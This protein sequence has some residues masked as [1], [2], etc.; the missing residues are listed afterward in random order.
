MHNVSFWRG[1]L[2]AGGLMVLCGCSEAIPEAELQEQ[3][4]PIVWQKSG[5]YSHLGRPVRILARDRATL[6]QVPVTEIPVD[7][8]NEMVLIAGVG[9]TPSSEVG[10][11]IARVW[12]KGSRIRVQEIQTH[13]GPDQQR[14]LNPASPWAVAVIPRSD[15]NVEGYSVAVPRGLIAP[16]PRAG[17][18]GAASPAG[19][20]NPFNSPR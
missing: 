8:E 4:V 18:G 2:M 10:I 5:T 3:E 15:L 12:E 7:F 11:Q 14:G 9:P 6:A 16:R 20:V 17:L 1:A 19:G 13:P